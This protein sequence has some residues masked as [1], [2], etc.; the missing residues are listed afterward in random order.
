VGDNEFATVYGG[1]RFYFGGPE[2]S[3]IRRHRE[4]DPP[5]DALFNM[6]RDKALC[7]K[8]FVGEDASVTTCNPII[9]K[10]PD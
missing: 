2:K 5:G 4:D 3:L 7:D 10:E 1:I 6:M 9:V 8:I